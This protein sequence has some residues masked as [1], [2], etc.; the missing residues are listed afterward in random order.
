MFCG[1]IT[2]S[3]ATVAS[4]QSMMLGDDHVLGLGLLARREFDYV[5]LGHM[6]RHQTLTQHPPVVYAGSI[7]RVDFGEENDDKGFVVVDIDPAKPQ[8]ERVARWEFVSANPRPMTTIDVR[9]RSGEDP[10]E[11][12]LSAVARRQADAEFARAI[13]RLRI[14]MTAEQEAS[15]REREVRQALE[16][17]HLVAGVERRVQRERRT[18]PRRGRR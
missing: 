8:G 11:A 7:E 5:A 15:F 17:A 4:E 1:H 6:H 3:G 14:E 16:G 9:A 18:R 2:V 13:V 12:A 10:T